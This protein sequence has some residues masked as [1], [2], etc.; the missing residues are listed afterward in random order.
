MPQTMLQCVGKS[1]GD[2]W[3]QNSVDKRKKVSKKSLLK[4]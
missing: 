1:V 3:V 2:L 4:M